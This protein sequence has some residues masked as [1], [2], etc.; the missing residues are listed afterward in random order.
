[1]I[2]SDVAHGMNAVFWRLLTSE[3]LTGLTVLDVGTGAG[4]VALALAPHCRQVVG[5]DRDAKLLD[6]A[7]RRAAGL[8]LT[9]VELVAGDAEAM[10]YASFAPDVVV[11][12][13]C[14]S[15][16]IAE[17]AGRA[18]AA[19]RVFAFV[20]FHADHW[21]ETGR[22][23]RF[24]YDEDQARDLLARTGFTIEHLEVDRDVQTFSSLEEGL[25]AAIG[26]E[27]KWRSD[28]R[29]VRYLKFLEKG[30]RT[31]TRSH[32]VVKARRL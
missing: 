14:M 31:L 8:N 2:Q 20:A 22:R 30:G 7:R 16:A 15:D 1:M 6:D 26:L 27:E 9:N 17:R 13:L 12:H 4:R 32:L 25:A 5:I 18:V 29:W 24:A 23:S 10:E 3:S 28:G 11:A 21:R 19:G